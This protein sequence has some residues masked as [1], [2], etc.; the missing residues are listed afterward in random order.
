MED[1]KILLNIAMLG[2][3]GFKDVLI[4][5]HTILEYFPHVGVTAPIDHV[6]G[7]L[8]ILGDYS[9]GHKIH[10]S[11]SSTVEQVFQEATALLSTNVQSLILYNMASVE[12]YSRIRVIMQLYFRDFGVDEPQFYHS[13]VP[14]IEKVV[15]SEQTITVEGDYLTARRVIDSI[16]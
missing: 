7:S 11:Y 3:L 9:I 8:A 6:Y 4:S 14:E 5:M 12:P 16:E 15:G 1:F 13:K 10:V 2:E